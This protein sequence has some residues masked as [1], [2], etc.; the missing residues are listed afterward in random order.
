MD[1]INAGR[2]AGNYMIVLK[3]TS[4]S[5]VP[6]YECFIHIISVSAL[7]SNYSIHAIHACQ[8]CMTREVSDSPL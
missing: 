1:R 3:F 6:M 2:R 8:A 7:Q 4:S 5:E